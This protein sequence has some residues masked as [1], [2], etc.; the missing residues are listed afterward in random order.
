MRLR[1]NSKQKNEFL[2]KKETRFTMRA[3]KDQLRIA[4]AHSAETKQQEQV[5]EEIR[6][7]WHLHLW[8]LHR[9]FLS[10]DVK[11]SRS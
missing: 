10:E 7:G 1:F 9:L 4:G 3:R 2:R 8:G 5:N 6:T 11:P